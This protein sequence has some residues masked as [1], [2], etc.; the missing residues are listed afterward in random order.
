MTRQEIET[1][2]DGTKFS[3]GVVAAFGRWSPSRDEQRLPVC[4]IVSDDGAARSELSMLVLP[5][6]TTDGV[7]NPSFLVQ[8]LG[9][10]AGKPSY[11][12]LSSRTTVMQYDA[13]VDAR[14]AT[15]EEASH[16]E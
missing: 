16:A 11:L 1:M 7:G 4:C 10:R 8:V 5:D 3:A 15:I 6:G 14:G 13:A 2:F 9:R 12:T